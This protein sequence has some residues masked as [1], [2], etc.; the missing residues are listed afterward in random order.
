MYELKVKTHIKVGTKNIFSAKWFV[1]LALKAYYF[2]DWIWF[3]PILKLNT[4]LRSIIWK[5]RC[6]SILSNKL[7]L[8]QWLFLL[9]VIYYHQIWIVVEAIDRR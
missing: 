5:E 7:F 1:V 2:R 4:Y 6:L 9:C 3:N 8:S